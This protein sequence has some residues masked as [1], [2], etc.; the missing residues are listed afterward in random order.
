[1]NFSELKFNTLG[2]ERGGLISFESQKSIPFPIKR[3]YVIY[4][5]SEGSERG[6][7]AH[8][9]LQQVAVCLS[10]SCEFVMDDGIE[11]T[12]VLLN[13]PDKGLLIKG[14]VWRVIRNFS[15]D[16]VLLLIA[17]ENYDEFD[18]IRDYDEFLA[19]K[20]KNEQA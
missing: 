2:D 7:H 1:M 5:P 17:S 12:K 18:Y 11:E 13:S 16:C 4:N 3:A 9:Q 10:G 8:R 15:P 20:E 6:F 19:W 14:L